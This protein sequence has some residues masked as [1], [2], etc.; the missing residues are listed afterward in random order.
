MP[1]GDHTLYRLLSEIGMLVDRFHRDYLTAN[2]V[3]NIPNVKPDHWLFWLPKSEGDNEA[4]KD[5]DEEY[6]R[7]TLSLLGVE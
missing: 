5:Q 6:R 3:K 2:G 4:G 7:H 1:L